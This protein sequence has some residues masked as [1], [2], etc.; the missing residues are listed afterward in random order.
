MIS[1]A[2][3]NVTKRFERGTERVLALDRVSLEVPAGQFCAV[4]GPSGS[5]KSTLLHL[6]AGIDRPSGGRVLVGGT[7]L[8]EL[9]DDRRTL[10]RRRRIGLVFQFFNLLVTLSALENVALPLQLDGVGRREAERRARALLIDLGLRERLQ[11]HPHQLSGGQMQRVAI[12]RALVS[13]PSL[14]LADEPTGNL[15]SQAGDEVLHLLRA[16]ADRRRHTV[17]LVTH[18]AHAASIGDRVVR[19]QDGRMVSD[20]CGAGASAA[21]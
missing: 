13:E 12:A 1:V 8:A 14:L 4:M 19:L 2:L 11:H 18:D 17:L 20:S 3:E 15:D 10:L 16:T 9:S 6:A 5:G 7:D 21:G